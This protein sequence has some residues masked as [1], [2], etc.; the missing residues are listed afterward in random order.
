MSEFENA[1]PSLDTPETPAS[2]L[3]VTTAADGETGVDSDPTQALETKPEG[4]AEKRIR[5]L[6]SR[7]KRAEAALAARET[8][9]Q[10][11]AESKQAIEPTAKP[12]P[13]DFDLGDGTYDQAKYLEAREDWIREDSR[14]VAREEFSQLTKAEKQAHQQQTVEQRYN[15]RQ[16]AASTKYADFDE[17]ASETFNTLKQIETEPGVKA[18]AEFLLNDEQSHDLEYHFGKNPDELLRVASLPPGRAF[19]EMGRIL[20]SLEKESGGEQ[21]EPVIPPTS[22]APAPPTPVK[23]PGPSARP[24]DPVADADLP[25]DVWERKRTAQLNRKK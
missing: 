11:V 15:E 22:K 3:E 4:R 18:I 20:A 6:L 12:K 9:R 19:V 7:A 21:D 8:V 10:P 25:Y 24:F 16:S 14:R 2:E 13:E 5:E 23:R 1:N 17:V